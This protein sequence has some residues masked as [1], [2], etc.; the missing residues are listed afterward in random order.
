MTATDADDTAVLVYNLDSSSYP[1]S[2]DTYFSLE[3]GN[4]IKLKETVDL[5]PPVSADGI[6]YLVIMATDSVVPE[7][8]GSTTVIVSVKYVNEETPLFA[9]PYTL[10]NVSQHSQPKGIEL[11]Q[12]YQ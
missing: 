10:T 4:T 6:Y 1:S 11:Y 5:D 2:Y 12:W 8:T 7:K 3:D 9:N